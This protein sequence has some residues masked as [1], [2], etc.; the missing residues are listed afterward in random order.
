MPSVIHSW[1]RC[2]GLALAL[3]GVCAVQ[4]AGDAEHGKVLGYTCLGCH[5]MASTPST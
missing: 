5:G 4:A 3:F 2:L 1:V